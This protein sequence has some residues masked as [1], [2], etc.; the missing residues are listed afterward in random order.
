MPSRTC[1]SSRSMSSDQR[2]VKY[3]YRC[4][5]GQSRG[6]APLE[7]VIQRS[8]QMRAV[9]STSDGVSEYHLLV[10]IRSRM[11]AQRKRERTEL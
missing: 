11:A 5:S 2:K 10:R 6:G 7:V 1:G 3:Q 8:Q 4:R 9:I